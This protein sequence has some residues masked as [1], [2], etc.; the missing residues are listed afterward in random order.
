MLLGAIADDV[1][2][3]TDLCDTLVGEGLR[4]VQ[5]LG[6]PQGDTPVP[7]A[8]AVVVALKSR[9][10]PAE[11]AV[12]M[13]LGALDWLR[14]GGARQILFKYCSTFDST[15]RGNI[16]PVADALA[17]ALDVP[18]ALHAPSF[19]ENGRTVYR[20]HL[21]V[22]DRLISESPMRHHPLTPMTD[23]DLVRVLGRQSPRRVGL[24]PYETVLAGPAAI[25]AALG[26]LA[27]GG[28]RHAIADA[29]L[30]GDLRSLGAALDGAPLLCGGSGIARGL[31]A[32]FRAA[33]AVPEG[34]ADA[35]PPVEGRSAVL[36][37]SCSAATLAQVA[38]M[39]A[40][41]PAFALDPRRAGEGRDLV[42]EAVEWAERHLDDGPILIHSSV[43][44][45]TLAEIQGRMGREAAGTLVEEMLGRIAAALVARGVRRLVIAGGETSGAVAAALGVR[46]LRIGPRIDRG[47]P[48]TL[49][50]GD[51]P[52]ALAFKSGNFGGP[53][54]FLRSLAMLDAAG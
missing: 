32:N 1:S 52:L 11:E 41:R 46:A 28:V 15:D 18:V 39:A 33:G 35:L 2:G 48:W 16:G 54:F 27:G 10:I 13:S 21:F 31:P 42:A 29:I 19:P 5:L 37:G 34:A 43:P 36:A 8:E 53:D 14:R 26:R 38:A 22:G 6:L 9:T 25:R 4:T 49:G 51:P 44:P 3:A 12:A 50:L 7:D 30:D 20:G 40:E 24:L 23:P 17:D 47:V 45:E